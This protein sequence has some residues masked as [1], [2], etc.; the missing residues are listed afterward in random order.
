MIYNVT[1]VQVDS[2]AIQ[3]YIHIHIFFFR[4]FCTYVISG[5]ERKIKSLGNIF[6]GNESVYLQTMTDMLF[7]PPIT[8][9]AQA[10]WICSSEVKPNMSQLD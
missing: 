10:L 6:K 1:L 2:K 9:N 5:E 8:G 7:C 3:L 4:C